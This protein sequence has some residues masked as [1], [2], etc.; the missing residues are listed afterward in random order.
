MTYTHSNSVFH[1]NTQRSSGRREKERAIIAKCS[2]MFCSITSWTDSKCSA[3]IGLQRR[4]NANSCKTRSVLVACWHVNSTAGTS[5]IW[6]E[7]LLCL[8]WAGSGGASRRRW[9]WHDVV[10]WRIVHAVASRCVEMFPW[11]ITTG[12]FQWIRYTDILQ[13]IRSGH[14]SAGLTQHFW[15]HV[16]AEAYL[17][18]SYTAAV[19]CYIGHAY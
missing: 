6:L 17:V 1:V 13:R 12:H 18:Y 7:C 5:H 3:T 4:N 19:S 15:H 9:V 10:G 8:L 2:V 14:V 11:N 16:T